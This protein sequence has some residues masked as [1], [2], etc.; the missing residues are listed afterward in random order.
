MS[1]R[2]QLPTAEQLTRAETLYSNAKALH[3]SDDEQWEDLQNHLRVKG[4]LAR[5]GG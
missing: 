2:V 3:P 1:R 5:A 4:L